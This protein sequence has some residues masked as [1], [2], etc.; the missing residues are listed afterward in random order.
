MKNRGRPDK[1]N[2]IKKRNNRVFGRNLKRLCDVLFSALGIVFLSPLWIIVAVIIK[3]NIPGSIL[4]RQTRV[5]YE[6][7]RFKILKFRTMEKNAVAECD[8]DPD[9]DTDCVSFTGK[10]IRR[11]K[12]DELPQL[13]SILIGDM[14]FI[15]P[16]PYIEKESA[17][18][19][20][21]RYEMR[22]GLTGLAQV[23]GNRELT[24]EERTAYDVDYVR[25][26]SLWLD[27]K[28]LLRTV[29]VVVF[30]EKACVRHRKG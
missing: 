28:V 10:W 5:G 7:S 8:T 19:S 14:S 22:P 25:N 16:R 9:V 30:G 3:L 18:L 12:L 23:Y 6:G 29:R 1:E 21:E 13:I 4:F 17:G 2:M 15:G 27:M 20:A 11:L 24:W 26:F